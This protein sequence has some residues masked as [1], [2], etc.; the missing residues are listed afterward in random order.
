[1]ASVTVGRWVS[2]SR[3]RRERWAK[4][5][6]LGV[7]PVGFLK[8]RWKAESLIATLFARAWRDGGCS[9][10]SIARQALAM[11]A[12]CSCV[13]VGPLGRQ[14]LQ[15]RNPAFSAAA[16][17]GWKATFWRSGGREAQEG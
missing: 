9:A 2:S 16:G 5:Y 10:D 4:A 11:A 6:C 14:R 8:A 13:S 3:T 12:A 17:E 7:R 15:E 1:M